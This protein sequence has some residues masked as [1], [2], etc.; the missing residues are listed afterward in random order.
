MSSLSSILEQHR[1][2]LRQADGMVAREL[3]YLDEDLA[4]D[5]LTGLKNAADSLA[6]LGNYYGIQGEIAVCAGDTRG[7]GSVSSALM[8]RYWALRLKAQC[9][10]A[11]R[12]L[13]ELNQGPNLTNQLSDAGCLLA[14]FI[15]VDRR[16]L[17]AP[18]ADILG[19]M[20]S[21]E[22]A[23]DAAYLKHRRFEPFML[24]LYGMYSAHVSSPISV[25]I[26]VY[27][28]VIDCWADVRGLAKAL[29]KVC[30]YHMGNIDDAGGTWDP[31]FKH[32]PFDL[33]PLEVVAI[34]TVRQRLGLALPDISHPLVSAETTAVE[35]IALQPN[36]VVLSVEAAYASFWS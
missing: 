35:H 34:L 4:E 27:Q 11:T 9:F 7:W 32:P 6:I 18:V 20:L 36:D 29:E 21:M 1:Q 28:Q 19:G 12:F 31:E 23:V 33:L 15:A 10:S 25:E 30:D 22:G 14:A 24:W 16:D 26:G 2:W 8:Y 17:A 5:S 13:G 3:E